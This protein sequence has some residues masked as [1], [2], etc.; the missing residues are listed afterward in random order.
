MIASINKLTRYGILPWRQNPTV[1]NLVVRTEHVDLL[2]HATL[3]LGMLALRAGT[4]SGQLSQTVLS[5]LQTWYP[6]V[7][8]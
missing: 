4:R 2:G 6:T 5:D 8:L 7:K 3:E 1:N